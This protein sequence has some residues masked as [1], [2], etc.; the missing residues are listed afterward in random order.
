M[1]RHCGGGSAKEAAAVLARFDRGRLAE[2]WA[3]VYKMADGR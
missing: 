1:T 2:E 3:D